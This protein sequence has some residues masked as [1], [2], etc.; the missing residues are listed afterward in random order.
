MK[1]KN[2]GSRWIV[3]GAAVAG[4]A[5]LHLVPRLAVSMPSTVPRDQ[6]RTG[7][8]GS[9]SP[10]SAW[11]PQTTVTLWPRRTSARANSYERVPDAPAGVAKC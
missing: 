4:F 10:E 3:A 7:S 8:A 6:P 2:H 1:R 9:S 5:A 11:A